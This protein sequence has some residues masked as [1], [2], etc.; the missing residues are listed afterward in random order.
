MSRILFYGFQI[1][2]YYEFYDISG[3]IRNLITSH[4]Q[5]ISGILPVQAII[6]DPGKIP[7]LFRFSISK[8]FPKKIPLSF[9]TY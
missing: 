3:L 2:N 9:W 7:K 1:F 5:I 8:G 6:P 4:I